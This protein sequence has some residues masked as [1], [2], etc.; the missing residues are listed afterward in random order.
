MSNGRCGRRNLEKVE[1]SYGFLRVFRQKYIKV[2]HNF[3]L[4]EYLPVVVVS[5]MAW[6]LK[7]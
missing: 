7:T 6:Q 4:S 1:S 3:V 2:F 5:L